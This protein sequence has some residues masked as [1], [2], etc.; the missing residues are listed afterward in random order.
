[1][2]ISS[3]KN[4]IMTDTYIPPKDLQLDQE[5]QEILKTEETELLKPVADMEQQIT[6]AKEAAKNTLESMTKNKNINIRLN[7]TDVETIKKKAAQAGLPYQT[8]IG[9]I[10]HQYA[11]GKLDIK[12]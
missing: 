8:L 6:L 10:L 1:M 2:G 9:S 11:T 7:L 4:Y 5:E 12:L 3:I